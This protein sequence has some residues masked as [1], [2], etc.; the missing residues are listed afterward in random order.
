M[1]TAEDI[2]RLTPDQEIER[3]AQA[4]SILESPIWLEACKTVE[5]GLAANRQSIPWRETEM[6]TRLIIAEQIY[7]QIRDHLRMV[8]QTGEMAR[9]KLRQDEAQRQGILQRIM[10]GDFRA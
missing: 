8:M 2:Q 9:L 7:S 4:R 6:H 5:E 3:E 10:S 1:M